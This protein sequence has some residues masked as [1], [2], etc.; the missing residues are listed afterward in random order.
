MAWYQGPSRITVTGVAA[1]FPQRAVVTVDGGATVLVIP[2]AVGETL[3]IDSA[4]FHLA[5]EHEYQGVWRPNIRAVQSAWQYV[6]TGRRQIVRSKDVD[7]PRDRRERNFVLQIDR[8]E[9]D[10]PAAP[11]QA[12]RRLGTEAAAPRQSA[13][14]PSRQVTS[15]GSG[16]DDR[17]TGAGSGGSAGGRPTTS[18]EGSTAPRV[19]TSGQDFS[20]FG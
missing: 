14:A 11:E 7:W 2:G 17:W 12:V 1:D 15:G 3:M 9:K 19:T 20:A 16:S 18:S 13:A 6:D 10:E 4:R 5:L 8:L